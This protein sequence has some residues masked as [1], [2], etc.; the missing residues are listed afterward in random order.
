M[1]LPIL[2]KLNFAPF[3]K[4]PTALRILD[5]L[6]SC[7]IVPDFFKKLCNN[8]RACMV[9]IPYVLRTTI[10][11]Y[12]F[13]HVYKNRRA[14]TKIIISKTTTQDQQPID[15]YIFVKARLFL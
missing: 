2:V 5:N 3:S 11:S 7:F 10:R 8:E 14:F 9:N 4:L 15:L 1:C 12:F 13:M 6:F